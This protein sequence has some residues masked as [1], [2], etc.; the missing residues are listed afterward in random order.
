MHVGAGAQ[1]APM[2]RPAW[3]NPETGAVTPM[4]IPGM[5]ELTARG[6]ESRGGTRPW[7]ASQDSERVE[8][9]ALD[10]YAFNRLRG[11][12]LRVEYCLRARQREKAVYVG[13]TEGIDERITLRRY[14]HEL[15]FAR[16]WMAG[17]LSA[18]RAA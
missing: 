1:A 2:K 8:V 16:Q 14:R 12:V 18:R 5:R 3:I 4:F 17:H 7:N 11:V 15:D 6:K 10:L 13:S 9:A